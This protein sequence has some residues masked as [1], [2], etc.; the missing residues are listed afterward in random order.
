MDMISKRIDLY[1]KTIRFETP[2]RIPT[3]SNYW[4]Y[5]ILEAGYTLSEGI[6]DLGKL[7]DAVTRFMEKYQFDAYNY[8]GTR[9]PFKVTEAFD[10]NLYIVD[11]EREV[12]NIKDNYMMEENEYAELTSDPWKYI[13]EKAIPRKCPGVLAD[14]A[15]DRFNTAVE[16]QR[17]YL[18]FGARIRSVMDR[19]E[20]PANNG[21][22]SF[23][24]FELFFNYFR[25][26][27]NMAMDLRRHY[28]ELLDAC[29]ACESIAGLPV[30]FS[31]LE[32]DQPGPFVH[33]GGFCFLGHSI[34]TEK[35]YADFYW[36][37]ISK[38]VDICKSKDKTLHLFS[39]SYIGRFDV[40]GDIPKGIMDLQPEQDDVFELRKKFPNLALN[41]GMTSTTLGK[42]SKEDCLDLA[43]KL[44]NELGPGFIMGQDKMMSFRH[45]AK[46]ENIMAV[47]EFCFSYRYK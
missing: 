29:H 43:K 15:W 22:F 45:D 5:M 16:A 39:E 23:I 20:I 30:F 18:D 28:S 44:V 3:F 37:Y 24:P 33:N 10:G 40:M 21:V 11:D 42:G 31:K 4:T 12:L 9:N 1:R 32:G 13:W 34:I 38:A 26:I 36:P 7:E 8:T 14:D 47:Q 27:K 19:L 35:Q 41:G 6:Y 2:E 17:E 25:G 46:P